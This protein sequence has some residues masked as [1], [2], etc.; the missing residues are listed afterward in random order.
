M[1]EM[2]IA[3]NVVDIAVERARKENAQR[4]NEI[5]LEIGSLSGVL[6]DSLQFCFESAVKNTMAESAQ[7][8]IIRCQAEAVCSACNLSFN[9]DEFVPMCPQ[10]GQPVFDVRNGR[11]MKI[12]Y[13]NVD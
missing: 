8:K 13:I 9:T 3:I 5:V 12:K 7:I 2:S 6:I 10:C 1:H 4:I 11:V